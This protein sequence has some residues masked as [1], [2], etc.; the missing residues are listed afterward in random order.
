MA[1]LELCT[2][3]DWN[4]PS[5]YIG[6]RESLHIPPIKYPR[7]TLHYARE[8]ETVI[9]KGQGKAV[10]SRAKDLYPQL[11]YRRLVNTETEQIGIA[12]R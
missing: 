10:T 8:Q 12:W 2:K 7:Y 1:K 5:T 4:S 11:S 9:D 6:E 3:D